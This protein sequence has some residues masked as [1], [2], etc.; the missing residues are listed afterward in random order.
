MEERITEI[1]SRMHEEIMRS[2]LDAELKHKALALFNLSY[3]QHR[4]M[5][6]SLVG[7]EGPERT[8]KVKDRYSYCFDIVKK[9]MDS[10]TP[11]E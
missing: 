3:S 1:V 10:K 2:P 7:V 5:H 6:G 8:Q 4:I 9:Y 11:E